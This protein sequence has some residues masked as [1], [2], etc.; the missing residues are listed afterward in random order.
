MNDDR[1]LS[2][3][4]ACNRCAA[5]CDACA[6]A[7]LQEQDVKALAECIRTD[8][9]CAALCRL[10]AGYMARGSEFAHEACELCA[11]ICAACAAECERHASM[12]AH[13]RDCAQACRRCED[14]CLRVS[15][16]RAGRPA[17][18]RGA[19]AS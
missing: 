12:H 4:D 3:I 17:H 14:E 15:G 10:A 9:D 13:C 6:G 11:E 16:L 2:C 5:A 1:F 8:V 7:C 18:R 19:T